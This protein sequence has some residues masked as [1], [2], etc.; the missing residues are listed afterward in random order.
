MIFSVGFFL[1][2]FLVAF[3]TTPWV[4]RL[5][6]NG[7][8][9]DD[10]NQSRKSH[11]VPT[12]RLGG[13]PL[14][15]AISLGQILIFAVQPQHAATWFPVLL[16]SVLMYGLGLWDDLKPLGAR[17]KLA[18]QI[19]T[20]TL[21][22]AMGLSIERVSYPGGAWSVE[23]GMWSAPVTIFWLIAVPNIVNL[24][25]GFDGL[26]GGLG[27]FLAV[28]L[29]VVGLYNEQLAVAWYAFT[30]AGALL[31]FLVFNF[32]PARIFL[33]DGGAYLIGF[34]IAAL[35]LTSSNKGSVAVVLLV[36][37]VALGVPILDTTFALLR[38]AVRGFP[39]FHA[40]DEHF[41]HRLEKLGFSKRRIVL[42]IYGV[43]VVLSLLAL[44]IVWTQAQHSAARNWRSFS[45]LRSACCGTSTACATGT[46]CDRKWAGV[47]AAPQRAIRAASGAV[48]RVGSRSLHDQR[49]VLADLSG[50]AAPGRIRGEGRA[51]GS[52][53]AAREIQRQQ[54]V[55]V[56]R[57]AG[58]RDT[59]RVAAHRRVLPSRIYQRPRTMG[60]VS[61]RRSR[62]EEPKIVEPV[63]P[64]DWPRW[65]A[66]AIFGLLAVAAPLAFGAVD[67]F[68]Q[69]GLLVLLG[70]GVL[71]SPPEI[72]RV[73]QRMNVALLTLLALVVLKEFGPAKLFGDTAWRTELVESYRLALPWTHNP[74]P[75]RALDAL[76]AVAAGAVWFVWVRSLASVR[77]NR[78]PL[79]WILFSAA[80]L[81]ALLSF[82]AKTNDTRA[83][84][85]MRYTPDWRGF[86]P[87]PNR[88][89]TACFFAISAVFG[90]G[91]TTWAGMRRKRGLMVVG[92]A[93]I[94]LLVGALFATESRGGIIAFCG[95]A[96]I[97]VGF[98]LVKLRDRR[99]LGIVFAAALVA[100][101]IA[102]VF[103]SK[104]LAR[105]SSPEGTNLSNQTRRDVWRDTLS[106]WKDAPLFGHGIETFP[107][108]FPIYEQVQL[109]DQIVLH[110]ESSWLLWLTELGLIPVLLGGGI[111]LALFLAQARENFQSRHT[112]YLRAGG[113]AA[114]AGLLA[115]AAIDVPAHRWGTAAFAIAALGI[116]CPWRAHGILI[117]ASR[118]P[119]LVVLGIACFW[120]L[121]LLF[122][123][124]AWSPLSLSRLLVQRETSA[125]VPLPELESML[126]FFPL[127]PALHQAVGLDRLSLFGRS[128]GEWQRHFQIVDRLIP[129]SWR[130]AAEQARA[131]RRIAPGF[132]L[133]AWQVAIERGG[134]QREDLLE[135]AMRETAKDP[136]ADEAWSS[137]AVAHPD[138]L[139][140]YARFAP[141]ALAREAF[142]TWWKLRAFGHEPLGEREIQ[143]CYAALR[144]WGTPAQLAEWMERR[145]DRRARDAR[146]W[147]GIIQQWGDEAAAWAVLAKAFPEP[148]F[149]ETSRRLIR[150]ELDRR[151]RAD[152]RDFVNAR[153]LAQF[154]AE[155]DDEA[156]SRK[157]VLDVARRLEAPDWFVQ[158]AAHLHA[159]AG[160][161]TEA[162]SLLLREAPPR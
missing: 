14:M 117:P 116:A 143:S 6:R 120:T 45:C 95:A 17:R 75:A 99:T 88:N 90:A 127:S 59:A 125:N 55:D 138:L 23:L 25:D 33:G 161:L 81:V 31:G 145:R 1:L 122:N 101:T 119:A 18:G 66:L 82:A 26:A 97:F 20:A 139:L 19:L 70:A 91:C 135:K 29:G 84:F 79:A 58:A 13:A 147:A 104:S 110:P 8:G 107:H 134:H 105:F 151:W 112:F 56:A 148:E 54:A 35:S 140:T 149:P 67:R 159:Q 9:L 114:A 100:T 108:L 74:E 137:Y 106:M 50:H 144:R 155:N 11:A 141:D 34:T 153:F 86:G 53:R 156:G 83:I 61:R 41:H 65:I 4:I 73:G 52:R 71:V 158:K 24:I 27:L 69:I 38:R 160:E 103:G 128:S 89:H 46:M 44:S 123:R 115:H 16:G 10:P 3:L 98:V 132:S 129:S 48:A 111:F 2:G 43:C 7:I 51:R 28:T 22:Y 57:L 36:T 154:L 157:V 133:H 42:G 118:K 162:I 77:E 30:M 12:P 72:A 93:L 40:D 78:A 131:T 130:P 126:R 37:I 152:P 142:T 21:V 102:L 121:P 64:T 124:P 92:I 63:A 80:A 87:F 60:S 113:F 47:R 85:G 32:P 146:T 62:R 68:T 49:R 150:E 5:S 136:M 94:G 109:D 15:L 39:L 96:V 76:L